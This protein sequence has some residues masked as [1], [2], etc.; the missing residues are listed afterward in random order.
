M[1][2]AHSIDVWPINAIITSTVIEC[3]WN[4]HLVCN[5]SSIDVMIL[6]AMNGET[7]TTTTIATITC[8]VTHSS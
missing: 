7:S 3:T 5:D 6:E 8:P 1:S 2:K 4:G